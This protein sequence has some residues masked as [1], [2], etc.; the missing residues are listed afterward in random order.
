MHAAVPYR[1]HPQAVRARVRAIPASA[2]LRKVITTSGDGVS[3]HRRQAGAGT[4]RVP[5]EARRRGVRTRSHPAEPDPDC[6]SAP[7]GG[8]TGM[9]K[10][11]LPLLRHEFT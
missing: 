7:P 4:G 5:H 11:A 6:D 10:Y 1:R 9:M 2:T 3:S 8:R